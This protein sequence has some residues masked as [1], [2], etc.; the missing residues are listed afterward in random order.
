MTPRFRQRSYANGCKILG[1][2][3]QQGARSCLSSLES[4]AGSRNVSHFVTITAYRAESRAAQIRTFNVGHIYYIPILPVGFW[5]RWLCTI[6]GRDPH[7]TTKTGRGFKWVGLFILLLISAGLWAVPPEPDAVAIFWILRFAFPLGAVLTLIHLLRTKK[8]PSLESRLATIQ[9]A[10]D[11]VR[12]FCGAQLLMLASQTS[13]P[14]CGVVRT[15][16]QK[17]V[18]RC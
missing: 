9:P 12:P 11:T 6:C 8:E 2:L 13:C 7:V 1:A 3:Q 10:S 5:K 16:P 4:T 18:S 15:Y 14:V 17:S